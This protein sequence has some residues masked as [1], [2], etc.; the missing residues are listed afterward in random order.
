[1]SDIQLVKKVDPVCGMFVD[2]NTAKGGKTFYKNELYF[3]CSA[4]CKAKFDLAPEQY[5][6]PTTTSLQAN[7][8]IE[9]TCPMHPEVLQLGPGTCPKCGMALEPKNASLDIKED[10]AEY[11]DMKKRF[12]VCGILSIPLLIVSMGARHLVTD[13]EY[14][15]WLNFLEFALA[16]P[17]VIW[18]GRPFFERMGQSILRF[19][20]NMFTLIGLGVGVAYLYSLIATFASQWFPISMRNPHNGQLDL[21]F[22][23]AAVI[24]TL[25]LLGQVLELK[26]R[27]Q[28][29]AA[30][31]ALLGLAPK[32]ARLI[33]LDGSE[34]DVPIEQIMIGHKL[35]VR[36]GEKVPVDGE[37]I[38][39]Q[40]TVDESMITGEAIPVEKSTGSKVVAAT[41][42]GTGSLVI[43]A[44]KVGQETLLAQI[45]Q[46]VS[47][48]QRSRAPI[49]KLADIASAYFVPIVVM[50]SFITAILWLLIGPEPKFAHALV[51]SIAVLIIAC[52]CA[53]GLATP[54]SI[55]VATG[56]AAKS[57]ILFKDA[58]AIESLKKITVLILDKT[59]TLTLGKPHLV[60]I[61]AFTINDESRILQFA[62]SLENLSE[63]PLAQ[64]IVQGAK[65][66]NQEFLPVQ[67]FK[68]I[69]GKGTTG[70][71][72]NLRIAIGNKALM[73]QNSVDLSQTDQMI[74]DLR[75]QGQTVM[76]IAINE[77][78]VGLLGVADPIKN[79]SPEAI[80]QIKNL[81]IKV[82]M[83]TG[84]NS[85]TANSVAQ[86]VFI[87]EVVADVLPQQKVEIVKRLQMQGQIVAMAGDGI[88]DA[89][90]L[91]QADVGIAMGT[92]TDIAMKSAGVTLVKGDLVGITK[93]IEI[94]HQTIRNIKQNLFFA[95]FY[96]ALGV[97]V[98]AGVLY[99]FFG[100]L[101]SPVI[102]AIAMSLSSV[103]VI[104]NS[105]RL[106]KK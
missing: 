88:N 104:A 18:G 54:M 66:R 35:R 16:T 39:G 59:G 26:A 15:L 28:T 29:G 42:N 6:T 64:A 12:V 55:M 71:I 92:G 13:H 82:V 83:V 74:D 100:I 50:I 73:T 89:P 91:A 46:M 78:L 101:L 14:N 53:L 41:I 1:M 79:T 40:T 95:F 31:K 2:P 84:D 32:T 102:A 94:S 93:A 81:G 56:Q 33:R 69:T 10:Q 76:F 85:L 106:R 44:K 51:N 80:Q 98:A 86:K 11:H 7:K 27:G 105:L 25:V 23:P 67:N 38:S 43:E 47:E 70:E 68:S 48:A 49:Q 61:K 75:K 62:A 72:Q 65:E 4:K 63:H 3:F 5:L 57:G 97:P 30:I 77:Q 34:H 8:N 60:T 21:Y 20:P 37:V 99:P 52:P 58:E 36:P 19:S 24:V 22:E 90:A 45:I 96:N 17:I 9:Y 87:D 103:S